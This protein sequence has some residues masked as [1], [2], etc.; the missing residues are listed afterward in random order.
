VDVC[1]VQFSPD[2]KLLAA[3]L[4][5]NG[6]VRL[7]K[8]TAREP[9]EQP[10]FGQTGAVHAVAFSHDSTRLA[11]AGA[12][13]MVR[14]WNPATGQLAGELPSGHDT[15]YAVAFS[16]DGAHL[17]TGSA[18]GGPRLWSVAS[19]Q[20]EDKPLH[21]PLGAAVRAV[22][23]SPPD[24]SLLAAAGD[25]GVVQLWNMAS[26]Q[27][28]AE[29]LT[30][31]DGPLRALSFSPDGSLLASAG[32]DGMVRLWNPA[33]GQSA[34]KLSTGCDGP[35]RAVA[36]SSD[37]SLLASAGDDGVV[38][39]WALRANGAWPLRQTGSQ[40]AGTAHPTQAGLRQ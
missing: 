22:S 33:T 17:A 24:G 30:R 28:V 20:P 8:V 36:F 23:F 13:L 37:G 35:L 32:D 19:C 25:D 10:P 26:R 14:L 27:P 29:L 40:N 9:V 38:R 18:E 4:A 21:A 39:R 11:V 31:C 5:A 1:T 2:G 15:V 12:D 3:G 6:V 34:G 16:P 7:W